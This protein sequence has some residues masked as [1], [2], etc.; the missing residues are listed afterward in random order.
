MARLTSFAPYLIEGDVKDLNSCASKSL[1][2]VPSKSILKKTSSYGNFNSI[3]DI[4][5]DGMAKR[6]SPFRQI[7]KGSSSTTHGCQVEINHLNTSLH[8]GEPKAMRKS[9]L[10]LV[11][12]KLFNGS[13]SSQVAPM[14]NLTSNE[15]DVSDGHFEKPIGRMHRCV[16][17]HS[18]AIREYDR[19][20]GDNPS[21]R[22]GPPLSL[23]WNYSN[24]Y[25]KNLEE[26]EAERLYSRA[27]ETLCMNK[28]KRKIL[29]AVHWGH[30]SEELKEARRNTKKI[31]RQRSMTNMLQL[32]TCF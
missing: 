23:D 29:L 10:S 20:I 4:D 22:S 25:E 31:Q 8:L 30:T 17:F 24:S 27:K 5:G 15:A 18:V 32:L 16:S 26:Y 12:T 21:C 13:K 1:H 19:T 28:Y 2:K 7:A 9:C 11:S 6:K 14:P 3:V